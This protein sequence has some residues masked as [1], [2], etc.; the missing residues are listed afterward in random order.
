MNMRTIGIFG[1]IA[2]TTALLSACGE[3][4]GDRA[5]S[6]AGIGAGTGA[7][8]GAIFGGVGAIPGALIGGGIGA[9]TGALT[10]PDQINLGQPAWRNGH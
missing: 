9:G 3:L 7:V 6:G 8:V 4:Q 5:I 10:S 2:T 1:L